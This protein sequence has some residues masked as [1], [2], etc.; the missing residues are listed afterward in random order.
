VR[1][2][3]GP[4]TVLLL[5]P[6]GVLAAHALGYAGAGHLHAGL[7]GT[8][9]HP[10]GYLAGAAAVATALAV[11]GLLATAAGIGVGRVSYRRVVVLQWAALLVQ[12][13]IEHAVAAEPPASLLLAPPLWLSLVA[14]L[15]AG[16]GTILLLRSARAVGTRLVALSARSRPFPLPW[17]GPAP[18]AG[19]GLPHPG[20]K[21]RLAARGPPGCPA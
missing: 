8:A 20:L 2:R 7:G 4:V 1:L 10:H 14:Q 5:V 17:G 3:Q 12:E 6:A 13:G 21:V 19:M 9:D 18:A 15:V 16:A 11:L